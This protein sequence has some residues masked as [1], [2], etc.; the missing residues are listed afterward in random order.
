MVQTAV[1]EFELN[2][3]SSDVIIVPSVGELPLALN[4][5]L[6]SR[7]YEAIICIGVVIN[8]L[9]NKTKYTQFQEVIRN[10]TELASYSGFCIG[11][12]IIYDDS[13]E[14]VNIVGKEYTKEIV[15]NTAEMAKVAR[16][17]TSLE[18]DLYGRGKLHN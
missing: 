17:L 6:E 10:L 4:I 2:G 14:N 5:L 13:V 1:E 8:D 7:S 15:R 18:G 9:N 3:N 11:T 12:A 16:Q